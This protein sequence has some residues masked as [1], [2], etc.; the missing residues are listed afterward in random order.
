MIYR[1]MCQAKLHRLTV[2]ETNIHYEGSIT[3]GKDLLLAAD[4]R[5]SQ[6]VKV[7][8]ITNG[9][10]FE[11]YVISGRPGQVC[12]NGGAARLAVAGDLIIVI[13]YALVS[14]DELDNFRAKVI[15]VNSKNKRTEK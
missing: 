1:Q 5:E 9:E 12:L 6:K 13:A 8:N 10:R 7:V 3:I 2:T 14:E 15:H 11:T 4:I